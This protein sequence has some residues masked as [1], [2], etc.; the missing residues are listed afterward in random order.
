[1]FLSMNEYLVLADKML[2]KYGYR[3]HKNDE[4]AIAYVAH[5]MMNADATWN[6][7]KSSQL[8]WRYN[9]AKYAIMKLKTKERS[10]RKLVSLNSEVKTNGSKTV[11]LHELLPGKAPK[12]QNEQFVSVMQQA[13]D[14]LTPKQLQCLTMYYMDSLTMEAIGAQL[15]IS[16]QRVQQHLHKA[17]EILK[18]ECKT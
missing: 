4:D 1:M 15:S 17:L 18:N 11:S 10:K 13:K 9:Q 14:L 3:C 2:A 16:K 12:V 7:D 5:Y 8:T 6:G